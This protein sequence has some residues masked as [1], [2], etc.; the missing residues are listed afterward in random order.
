[1]TAT[2]KL[3]DQKSPLIF[4]DSVVTDPLHINEIREPAYNTDDGYLLKELHKKQ[5]AAESH[6]CFIYSLI[7]HAGIGRKA[8]SD[9]LVDL[10]VGSQHFVT[11]FESCFDH[12]E[13]ELLLF[14]SV[15]GVSVLH[16]YLINVS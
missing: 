3:V 8:F 16:R 14:F 13:N 15:K 7:D 1:M 4:Q 11:L 2:F 5:R 9:K 10:F 12:S 6:R